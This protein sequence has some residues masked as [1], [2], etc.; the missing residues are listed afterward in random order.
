MES[1]VLDKEQINNKIRRMAFQLLEHYHNEEKI[2][3]VGIAGQGYA[4]AE[5]LHFILNNQSDLSSDL[6]K[7]SVNKV[8]PY[9]NEV[10][11][12]M[13]KSEIENQTIIIVDDV[14]NSG[15]TMIYAI[16]AFLETQLKEIKSLVLVDRSHKRFPVKA[17][18][19]GLS[20]ATTLHEHIEVSLELDNES[21]YLK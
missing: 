10:E 14:L 16:K 4:L 9:D 21:V 5:R 18:F 2:I 3:I 17:D 15:K 11:L 12:P 13:S 1:L 8:N 7:V 19:V 6:V 20:L